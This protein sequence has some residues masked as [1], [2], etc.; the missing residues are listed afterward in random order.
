MINESRI[1]F[2][3]EFLQH[4]QNHKNEITPIMFSFF[5]NVVDQSMFNHDVV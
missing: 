3:R 5:N 1:K 2:L 4:I